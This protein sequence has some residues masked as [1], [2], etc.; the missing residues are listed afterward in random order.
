RLKELRSNNGTEF[1]NHKLEEFCDEKE[2]RTMLNS[3]NLPKQFW[4]EAVN[5]ACYTQNRSIIV[6][7]HRKTA[8]DVFRGRSLNISNFHVFGCPVHIHNH[9]DHLGKF[10]DKVVNG[11]FLSYSP[12]AKAFRVF[13]IR[14]QELEESFHVTFSEDDEVISQSSTKGMSEHFPYIPTYDPLSTNNI[15]PETINSTD[16]HITQD[17]VPTIETPESTTS[18]DHPFINT[19]ESEDNPE[20]TKG[21]PL[22][23]DRWSRDGHI[24]LVNIIGEPLA[25]ITT[26]SII[27]YSKAA[28]AHECLYVNFL[29]E[30]E[31]KRLSEA[32]KEEG[33]IIV[34]RNKMDEEGVVTKNKARLVAKGYRQEEG[35]DYD[36][37]FAP[38]ARLEAIRIF[39]AYAS[40]MGFTVYQMDVK[41]AFLNGKI[42]KEFYV[43]KP[44]GFES[45]QFRNHV[46][47]LNK[48]LYGLKQAPRAWDLIKK[49]DVADSASVKCHMLPPNNLG[50]DESR[51]SVNETLFRDIDITDLLFNDL[52][53]K[54]TTSV[55]KKG[56][57]KGRETNIAYT[58]Y[59]SFIIEDLMGDNYH[60][61]ELKPMKPHQITSSTFKAF[62]ISKVPLTAYMRKVAKLPEI[63]VQSLILPSEEVNA[64][65][66]GDNS[67]SEIAMNPVSKPKATTDKRLK[68]KK[69]LSSSEPKA[70]KDVKDIP[71]EQVAI[72]QLAE[73]PV[74]NENIMEKEI[75]EE[76]PEKVKD[77]ADEIIPE[78]PY[79]TES[80]I[81]T[82]KS[83]YSTKISDLQD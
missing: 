3:A 35:I 60:N 64:K 9:R 48:A 27:R 26:K 67:L 68:K 66:A 71:K 78:N 25:G 2:A 57:N 21:H 42:A 53:T 75:V 5:T 16:S 43:E 56:E 24:E 47:K 4:G 6:K 80:E 37:T 10:I 19:H 20:P 18:D 74:P 32:L 70:L 13:N 15:I 62:S 44:P 50:P 72:T 52:I 76:S 63:P 46:F 29:F 59:L 81:Q 77:K 28:F 38:V 58:I 69:I 33:W 30:I 17:P 83:F 55:E 73:E 40:Y 34:F 39:L 11:L 23:Q 8:Y 61:S 45:S 49:Y 82:V 14:R 36:E 31:P 51:V 22:P 41:S 1:R 79:D 65:D 54:L 7:R 12:I